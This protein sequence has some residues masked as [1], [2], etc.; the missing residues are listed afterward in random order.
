MRTCSICRRRA[1]WVDQARS[2]PVG[3][4][5]GVEVGVVVGVGVGVGVVVGF[6]LR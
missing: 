6:S 4:G 5:V 1:T 2:K 3:V